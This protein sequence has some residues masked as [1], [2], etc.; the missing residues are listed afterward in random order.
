MIEASLLELGHD[1]DES[2]LETQDHALAWCVQKG[3]AHVYIM[4]LERDDRTYLRVIAPVLHLAPTVDEGKLFRRLLELN[5]T[6]VRG[7]AFAL[8][9][10]DVVLTS[11][12][13]TIDLDPSEVLEAIHQTAEY[14][15]HYDD[16]LVG[17]FGGR[18]AGCSSAPIK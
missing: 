8:R 12:R 3:S 2:R 11:E 9:E 16:I 10:G 14:A 1:P 18:M 13:T 5:S 7:A 4:L 6:E 15:D 17:Q